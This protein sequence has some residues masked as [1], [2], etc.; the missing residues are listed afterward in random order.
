MEKMKKAKSNRMYYLTV[1]DRGITKVNSADVPKAK[2]AV[3]SGDAQYALHA[4]FAKDIDDARMKVISHKS[5]IYKPSN[6]SGAIRACDA[7]FESTDKKGR[8][9]HRCFIFKPSC[10]PKKCITR[11][12]EVTNPYQ[13]EFP[14]LQFKKINGKYKPFYSGT[15]D[16]YE[17]NNI[18][19]NVGFD[20]PKQGYRMMLYKK[21]PEIFYPINMNQIK[22]DLRNMKIA[23]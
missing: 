8:L 4:V 22:L 2:S 23:T 7:W 13:E 3:K 16:L 18:P 12:S 10:S 19:V 20:S 17:I 11:L 9:I 21:K 15:N 14:F 5:E 1:S 6:L